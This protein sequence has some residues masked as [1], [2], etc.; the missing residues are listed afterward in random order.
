MLSLGEEVGGVAFWIHVTPSRGKAVGTLVAGAVLA[1]PHDSAAARELERVMAA[2]A[3]REARD[4]N[5]PGSE[6]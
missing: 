3:G 5:P 1:P 6:D 4:A 2:I